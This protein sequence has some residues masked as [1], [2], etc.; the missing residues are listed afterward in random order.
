VAISSGFGATAKPFSTT[1]HLGT[2]TRFL[3][4]TDSVHTT[5]AACD[6][7]EDR[8]EDGDVVHALSVV[9]PGTDDRDAGDALNVAAARLA[10]LADVE[11]EPREGDA[12]TVV[13]EAASAADELVI[14]ARSGRPGAA[15]DLGSTARR[16]LAGVP[17]PTVV[18]PVP[19]L[20]DGAE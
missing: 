8:L 15:A 17:V 10:T 5:A 16:M 3:L 13:V 11:T 20:D 14:G 4:A 2:V 18:V 19:R 9:E 1:P 7:L 12:A 6:Y